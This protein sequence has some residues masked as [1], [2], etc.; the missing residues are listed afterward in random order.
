M[1]ER[2]VGKP[3]VDPTS[4]ILRRPSPDTVWLGNARRGIVRGVEKGVVQFQTIYNGV[5]DIIEVPE[6]EFIST[7][8]HTPKVSAGHVHEIHRSYAEASGAT[9][10]ARA[11]LAGTQPTSREES[12]M[13]T[14]KPAAPKAEKKPAA[15]KAEKKPAAPKA[16]KKPAAPKKEAPSKVEGRGRNSAFAPEMKITILAESNPK[17]AKAAERFALYKNGMTV[18]K[19]LELGGLLADVRWDAKQG[20][21]KVE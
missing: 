4:V 14:K 9:A 12:S 16:E 6:K 8:Q 11:V 5:V 15:P 3:F 7:Y 21:I 13:A 17:R 10:K 20:F 18:A 19:Y 1:R 2:V